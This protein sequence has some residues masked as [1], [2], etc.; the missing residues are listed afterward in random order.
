MIAHVHDNTPPV[1]LFGYPR[2]TATILNL[3]R[4]L[5]YSLDLAGR[6]GAVVE[7]VGLH[8]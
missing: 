1:N 6:R 7:G 2:Q 8:T 5:S 4:R 3:I